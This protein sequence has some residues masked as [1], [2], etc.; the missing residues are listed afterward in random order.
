M[1]IARDVGAERR[2]SC[3]PPWSLAHLPRRGINHRSPKYVSP[4][5][6]SASFPVNPIGSSGALLSEAQRFSRAPL[7]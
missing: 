2:W 4:I 7:G 5:S 6:S 3:V 1:G